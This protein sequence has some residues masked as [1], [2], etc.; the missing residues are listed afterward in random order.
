MNKVEDIITGAKLNEL[1]KKKE[2]PKKPSKALI[3]LP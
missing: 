1:L 2:E 3:V